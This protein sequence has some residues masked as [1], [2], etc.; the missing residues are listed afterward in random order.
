MPVAVRLTARRRH[1]TLNT[2][3]QTFVRLEDSMTMAGISDTSG[4]QPSALAWDAGRFGPYGGRYVPETLMH[5][6]RQL[7]DQYEQAR[8]DAE[9][10]RQFAYYLRQYVG[11]PSP[12]YFAERL[13][14]EAGGARIFLKRE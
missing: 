4:T 10:Q 5:A 13:T 6:L 1:P 12:L 9:F 8:D 2:A 3:F 11:R 14:R 7:A